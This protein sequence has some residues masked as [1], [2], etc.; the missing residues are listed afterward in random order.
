MAP[1]P[2]NSRAAAARLLDALSAHDQL[3]CEQV[4]DRLQ[5]LVE[6]ELAGVD[7]DAVPE[8][9]Q[10]LHHLD[11]CEDCAG[12][13]TALAED[14]SA[15][16]DTTETLPSEPATA[17]SFF[18]PVRQDEHVVLRIF[19]DA[20][21]RFELA[22]RM[23]QLAPSV[24][25]LGSGSRVTLFTDTLSELNG[26]PVFSVALSAEGDVAEL[27]VAIREAQA[28]PRWQIQFKA[29]DVVRTTT[30][31]ER[32]IAVF[33]QLPLASL[34]LLTLTCTELPPGK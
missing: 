24:A 22:L 6:A 34:Q 30:T 20:I 13:Y 5:A 31:D 3:S 25:T 21:R 7:V 9:A 23:P 28:T 27:L 26:S 15:F 18:P 10:I 32:G 4:Q 14:L 17:P 1:K 33:A 8:Y 19:G 11:Q 16:V 2:T 12:L 29:G